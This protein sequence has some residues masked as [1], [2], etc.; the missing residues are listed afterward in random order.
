MVAEVSKIINSDGV[1]ILEKTKTEIVKEVP[2]IP[3]ER[4]R[5]VKD[6]DEL[7]EMIEALKKEIKAKLFS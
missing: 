2:L 5:E 3:K 7:I 6:A 4:L 1:F